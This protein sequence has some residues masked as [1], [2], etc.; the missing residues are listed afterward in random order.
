MRLRVCASL[1]V[2]IASF[3][4]PAPPA[5]SAEPLTL[6]AA[7]AI[8]RERAPAI[9]AERLRLEEA[10][11]LS[12]R[13]SR[14]VT[15]NPS[16]ET[17]AGSRESGDSGVRYD[18]WEVT[19]EQ[20]LGDLTRGPARGDAAAATFAAESRAVD[21]ATRTLL[22]EVA[23]AFVELVAL[24]RR[25]NLARDGLDAATRIADAATRRFEA[26]DV[27]QIDVNLAKTLLARASAEHASAKADA[28]LAR[29]RLASLLGASNGAAIEVYGELELPEIS[30]ASDLDSAIS[31][32]PDVLRLDAEIT[33]ARASIKLASP[34]RA[35]D[36]GLV[37]S[38]AEEEG[39]RV[40]SAG[41]RLGVPIADGGRFERAEAVARLARLEHERAALVRNA[42][43]ELV[44]ARDAAIALRASALELTRSTLPLLAENDAIAVESYDAGQIGI[45]DL[46]SVRRE[47]I[48]T[49]NAV[50][51]HWL[52]ARKAALRLQ[53]LSGDLR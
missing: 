1:A 15:S 6:D 14:L 46:A 5:L 8:A 48:D 52:E 12:T 28:S 37:A 23:G 7:L 45:A 32:R 26:G 43:T 18:E 29:A 3:V 30:T 50:I 53:F 38:A 41:L 44:A 4:A 42:V 25:A 33:A 51:Q 36:W 20:D 17:L 24:D 10:R 40:A 22:A 47:S 27:A 11:V 16:I 34:L 9:V 21:D 13:D 31:A 35:L 19:L 49:R 2:S 39:D